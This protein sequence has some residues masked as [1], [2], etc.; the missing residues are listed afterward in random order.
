MG[1]N[2]CDSLG[3]VHL[4]VLSPRL[5]CEVRRVFGL[6]GRCSPCLGSLSLVH[7]CPCISRTCR[8]P[9]TPSSSASPKMA[10]WISTMTFSESL[11]RLPI[12]QPIQARQGLGS[13]QT[14]YWL[15][16]GKGSR[17]VWSPRAGDEDG[18]AGKGCRGFKGGKEIPEFGASGLVDYLK[19]CLLETSHN[20]SPT[21]GLFMDISPIMLN[22]RVGRPWAREL[23]VV[24]LEL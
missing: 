20:Q 16:R 5:L 14:N 9:C 24:A 2:P 19:P 6:S 1:P 4:Y 15:E 23:P 18:P 22:S 17:W 11:V 3:S 21:T 7:S 8:W 13:H 10:G 12:P